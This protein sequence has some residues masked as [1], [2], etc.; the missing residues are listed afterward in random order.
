MSE[1]EEPVLLKCCPFLGSIDD[2]DLVHN[3]PTI[4]NVCRA[5]GSTTWRLWILPVTR[6]YQM[7]SLKIQ[8]NMCLSED[9]EN[10]PVYGKREKTDSEKPKI[11]VEHD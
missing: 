1:H 3:Y 7:I 8:E 2:K 9:W 5:T 6:P 10:C 11:E 4:A